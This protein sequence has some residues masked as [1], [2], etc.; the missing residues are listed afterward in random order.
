M[1]KLRQEINM[2]RKF[3]LRKINMFVSHFMLIMFLLHAVFGSLQMFGVNISGTSVL[4]WITMGFVGVHVIIGT[5]L[6]VT[7]LYACHK[8]GVSYFRGNGLFWARRISGYLMI[9]LIVFH[10]LAF[11]TVDQRLPEFTVFRLIVMITLVIVLALHIIMN[12]KPLLI[13]FG[14]KELKPYAA[15]I[16]VIIMIILSIATVAFI[17][18]FIRW[19]S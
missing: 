19:N 15:D 11:R 16:Y 18:Y 1:K 14:I 9:V 12:V 4:G 2:K 7:T 17:V 8:A 10:I 13:A 3:G 5:I 6:T